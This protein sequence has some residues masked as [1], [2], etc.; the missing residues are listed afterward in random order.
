MFQFPPNGK[1]LFKAAIEQLYYNANVGVSIP[2]ERE[3]TFQGPAK[4]LWGNELV[5]FQFPPNGKGLFKAACS[6]LRSHQVLVSIPYERE[7]AFQVNKDK[8]ENIAQYFMFQFPPNGK[9][10]FKSTVTDEGFF[11]FSWRSFNSLRTGKDFS[12]SDCAFH[13][14]EPQKRFQFPTNGKGLFKFLTHINVQSVD[15]L[16]S[17]PYERERAFQVAAAVGCGKSTVKFQFPPNG[18]GLF[19]DEIDKTLKSDFESLCF[20][21]LRTGKGF[22]SLKHQLVRAINQAFQFPPN[23]KGLF[24]LLSKQVGYLL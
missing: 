7:R 6:Q 21:S 13:L 1:G 19:K 24:K 14:P 8:T 3:R 15:P 23:G 20:N 22:S 18:K 10:L 12:R 2:S 5:Q 9:G 16:V 11:T 4:V 17:I